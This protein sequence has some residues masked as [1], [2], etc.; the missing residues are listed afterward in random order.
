[1]IFRMF[2]YFSLFNDIFVLSL[3]KRQLK[4]DNFSRICINSSNS[5]GS[6]DGIVIGVSFG[7]VYN[8]K[9]VHSNVKAI[10]LV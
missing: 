9:I 2:S 3:S 5:C 10:H 7:E 6:S 4:I 1:M 8:G